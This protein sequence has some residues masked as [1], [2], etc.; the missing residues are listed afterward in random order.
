MIPTT[1]VKAK[2]TDKNKF[3]Q[4]VIWLEKSTEISEI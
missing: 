3:K 2:G 1:L 4:M